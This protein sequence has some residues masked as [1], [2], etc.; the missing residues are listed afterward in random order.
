LLRVAVT[1]YVSYLVL[2][3]L[4]ITPAL[5]FLPHKYIKDH[6][7]RSLTTKWV[8]L[9]PFT[10]SLEIRD[11]QL[12]DPD[13][14]RLLAF[15]DASVNLST[16]SLWQSGWVLDAVRLHGLNLAVTR[17][18]DKKF[19][20]SDLLNADVARPEPQTTAEPAKPLP[21]VTVHDVELQSDAI[22]LTDQAR[23]KPYTSRW[24]GLHIQM[25]EFSTRLDAGSPFSVAAELEGG[26]KLQWDGDLSIRQAHSAGKFSLSGLD[27]HQAWLYA[28]DWLALQLTE[29]RLLAEGN[30]EVDWK[31][32]LRYRLSNGH[33]AISAVNIV[34]QAPTQLPDTAVGLKSLDIGNIA[35]DSSTR[36][37]T[38]DTVAIDELAASTWREGTSV[39]LQQLFAVNLPDD[40]A[41]EKKDNTPDWGLELH[42][43]Q[44]HNSKLNWRSQLTDPQE[45]HVAPIEASL[46]QI[47]WP[48]SGNTHLALS[49]TVN[50][51]VKLSA[52]STLALDPGNGTIEYALEG[53]PLAWFNPNLPKPLKA[54]ITGGQVEVKGQL[55]LADYSP[56]TIALDG[57]IH[58]FSARREAE[59]T[60]LTGFDLVR[61]ENLAVDVTQHSVLLKKL[62]IDTYMGRLHIQKDGSINAANIW[63]REVGD[64]AQK[65]A[66]QL[67]ENKPW[68]FSIPTISISDSAIDY[69]DDSLPIQFRTVIGDIEGEV[70]GLG[71]DTSH[72]ASVDLNGSVD[73]YAPVSLKGKVIP[74]AKPT[75]LDLTLVFNGVDMALLSPYASTYAGYAIDQG[76]LNLNLHY[77]LKDHHLQGDNALRIEKLK[78]GEKVESAKAVDL[79]LQLALAILTDA[80]GVIEVAVPVQGDVDNPQFQIG[81]L[82]SKAFINLIAKAVTAPFKLLAGLVNSKSD[83]QRIGFTSGSAVLSD[84][85]KDKLKELVTALAQRP[86]LSVVITGR[87]NTT[88][89][90]ERLQRNALRAQLLAEGL[91]STQIK[92]MGD[93]WE[94]AITKRFKALP[95]TIANA[96]PPPV[97]EQYVAVWHSVDVPDTQLSELL[98]QRAATVKRYLL[99]EAGLAPERAVIGE[100]SLNG[101][102]NEFSGVELSIGN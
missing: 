38:V 70:L 55:A 62:T 39:S 96:E 28:E 37:A 84:Q 94:K 89:D 77:T 91:S 101:K 51:K 14:E 92:A 2:T 75:N 73:G 23:K 10:L 58:N 52:S 63:K 76:L 26:G 3:L 61:L 30:Y 43:A 54:T 82:L 78:L 87:L 15:S 24:N 29:G 90:R 81:S 64:Q 17:L 4:V 21:G 22:V 68:T 88:A 98:G 1:L 19:N 100:A 60:E 12:N 50:D 6:Y 47:S 83:L 66:E 56:T 7:G 69:S 33:V 99:N 16:Q 49:G 18:P 72:P 85:N 79:P 20:F 35:L 74:M 44:L 11:A 8:L 65:I 102:G 80:H 13:G 57:M 34:P 67:T 71:S 48:L 41:A 53:L 5:N 42:K 27:L 32:A 59:E 40:Q 9:N 97:R 46:E 45:L 25:H 95:S 86:K 31:D 93:D 36:K